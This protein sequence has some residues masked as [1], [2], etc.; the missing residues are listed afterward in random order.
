M[1]LDAQTMPWHPAA[2]DAF[3]RAVSHG[4]GDPRATY[5]EGR[6]A[7]AVLDEARE[8]VATVL[9]CRPDEVAFD[10]SGAAAARRAMS[11]L[12]HPRQ[13]VSSTIITSAVET[14]SILSTVDALAL[15]SPESQVGHTT[16]AVDHD[17]RVDT[18][19]LSA[20]AQANAAFAC[21]QAA[22]AETGV[23]QPSALLADIL[24]NRDIPWIMDATAVM[25]YSAIPE[26]WSM[27]VADATAWG[28]PAGVGVMALRTGTRWR[29]PDYPADAYEFGRVPGM[30]AVPSI[31]A[32]AAALTAMRS[33]VQSQS[34][35]LQQLS[36][37]LRA[38]VAQRI[39]HVQIHSNNE[40]CPHITSMSFLYTS[41]EAL[42]S[43]LDKRGF[44]VGSGSACANELHT[45]SH[46]LAAMGRLTE[47]NLRITLPWDA[48]AEQIDMF[49]DALV[50]TV[51]D[52]RRA[53]GA[54][55]L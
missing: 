39:N 25:P 10:S 49:V 53:F 7:A 38:Q 33:D 46:V 27:A 45:P 54:A 34:A 44:A 31:A 5:A 14:A 50:D 35:R 11:G 51:A 37:Q 8:Q 2:R 30:P 4:W 52:V 41:G 36:S 22:N 40:G 26:G 12:F 48:T 18:D 24:A 17:G 23:M 16:I 9:G 32:A 21:I 13:R 20:A 28:G 3:E 29:S 15:N 43:R 42:A 47:G 6:R 55:D 19:A 1:L